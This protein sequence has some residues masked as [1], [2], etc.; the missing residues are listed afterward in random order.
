V[1]APTLV[2]ASSNDDD[3]PFEASAALASCAAAELV[4]VDGASHVGPLLG[5]SSHACARSAA[6]WL[7]RVSLLHE[8]RADSA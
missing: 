8:Q 4:R 2:L 7:E 1:R 3:V 5:R 6:Q